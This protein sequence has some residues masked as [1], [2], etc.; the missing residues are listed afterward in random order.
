MIAEPI[1][2]A[3]KRAAAE[4]GIRPVQAKIKLIEALHAGIIEARWR[5][6]DSSLVPSSRWV[7]ADVDIARETVILGGGFEMIFVDLNRADVDAWLSECPVSNSPVKPRPAY[8][9]GLIREAAKLIWGASGVP[10]DLPPQQVFKL[11][12]DKVKEL[13]NINVSKSQVL[14]ALK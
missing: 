14:R 5:V 3:I 6:N 4:L 7:G 2:D 1:S 8:K 12:G 9:S 13:H 10:G 11:V